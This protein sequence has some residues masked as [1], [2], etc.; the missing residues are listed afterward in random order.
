M[1]FGCVLL[2]VCRVVRADGRVDLDRRRRRPRCCSVRTSLQDPSLG[3][4]LSP[5]LRAP[6]PQ[7]NPRRRNSSHLHRRLDN[8]LVV[9]NSSRPRRR[10]LAHLPRVPSK[11]PGRRSLGLLVPLLVLLSSNNQRRRFL[12]Q[13][14]RITPSKR[15][16]RRSLGLLVPPLV[17]LSSNQRRQSLVNLRAV[18]SSSSNSSNNNPLVPCLVSLQLGRS[19]SNHLPLC[20][21]SPLRLVLSRNN[22]RRRLLVNLRPEL[23]SSSNRP[24][25]CLVNLQPGLNSSSNLRQPRR[26]LVNL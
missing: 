15:P 23:N 16:G 6:L 25:P 12:A 22:Q 3:V 19:S 13:L 11:R 24:H 8:Q 14:P 4:R 5:R 2:V 7:H 26:S 9:L 17:P 1:S 10:F 20:L 18:L 21:A